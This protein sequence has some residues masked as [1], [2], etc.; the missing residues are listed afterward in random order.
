MSMV[1]TADPNQPLRDDV[2]LLGALL[3]K[4]VKHKA[5]DKTFETVEQIRNL[6]KTG[7]SDDEDSLEAFQQLRDVLAQMSIQEMVPV[8][9]AFSMF[10]ALA[11][12]AEQNHRIRRRRAYLSDP[13]ASPQRASVRDAI[14]Q[15]RAA[16]QSKQVIIKALEQI[17]V[18]LVLTAHPTEVKRRTLVQKFNTIGQILSDR[19]RGNLTSHEQTQSEADL[20]RIISEIWMTDEIMRKRPTPVEEAR[21]G[22]VVFEQ[23]LWDAV[24]K[25]LRELN[26]DVKSVLDHELPL[27][28]CPI[29][30]GSWM[31]GDRDGNPNVTPDVTRRVE[32]LTRWLGAT[33]YYK[34]IDQLRAE[35]SMD[36]CSEELRKQVGDAAEPYRA[37]LADVRSR[38]DRTRRHYALIS[39]NKT[40]EIEDVYRKNDELRSDLMICHRSLLETG[41]DAIAQGRL[42][43][44][45]RRLNCFGLGLVRLDIRQESDRHTDTLNAITEHLGLGSYRDWDENQR[46]DFLVR[47][48]QSRR[49]LIPPEFNADAEVK[50]VLETFQVAAKLNPESLGAY[51]ISMA[52]TPSD[53]LAVALLQKEAGL[54][55][56][57]RIVPLFETQDDLQTAPDTLKT[58]F[59]IEWYR[60]Q[61]QGKQELMLGY[62][63]SAK[64]AGRLTAAW[65]LYKAQEGLVDVCRK[66]GVHLTLF[67]GRGG[68]VGRGGGPT[69]LAIMSQA[70]GSIEHTLRVTE[71]GE[72]I[73]AKFGL[74]GIAIRT[75]ELYTTATLQATLTPPSDPPNEY[76]ELMDELSKD[77]C[78][79]FRGL[80][81][82]TDGFVDYFRTVT[83]EPEFGALNIGSRPARRKP[84]SGIKTLRAI[85]WVFAWT[86]IRL[87]LPAWLGVGEALTSSIDRGHFEKLKQM[88]KTW[89]FFQ[90]TLDLIEMVFAKGSRR[91]ARHYDKCLGSDDQHAMG[92]MLRKRFDLTKDNILK[93][94]ESEYLLDSNHVLRRSID[95]RNPYVDPINL[96]QVELLNRMRD[97]AEEDPE[98]RNALLM[99]I[100]GIAA[101]LRNTG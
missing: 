1:M 66:E 22:L 91:I 43:D 63:D 24:P 39:E 28:F 68:T 54:S 52:T 50:D 30:F 19:D 78:S 67:H 55:P 3:G 76:R 47:E 79:T 12:I 53:V 77:A 61:I 40:S 58:L 17:D 95:V 42:L 15:L 2:R 44:I 101:G 9:R 73:Q 27:E 20:K 31:G 23:N 100:N 32:A 74:P 97:S 70:P 14:S 41:A 38:L 60:N 98:L 33:L 13:E 34:E 37:F 6:A 88:Y 75:L 93:I 10:L 81:R 18:E 62:S 96:L 64:D 45:I 49:P 85:P 36:E 90:S 4:T 26:L 7:R 56:M 21:G 71:Q 46:Q 29:R 25:F 69:H 16:G 65:D 72:M 59:G 82:H 5:G 87:M 11:N 84:G 83:P 99:T 48:L 51:V 57:M 8:T 86:Q 94:T 89:P 80:I 35:L 92:V